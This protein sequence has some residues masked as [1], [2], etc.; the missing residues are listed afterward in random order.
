MIF[1]QS[2]SVSNN[3]RG[4]LSLLWA[5][6]FNNP[7]TG[8]IQQQS[9]PDQNTSPG[10]SDLLGLKKTRFQFEFSSG[11]R[12]KLSIIV[13][14]DALRN[15]KDLPSKELD[16]RLGDSLERSP[17]LQFLD[18]YEI[19]LTPFKALSASFGVFEEI[20]R[21]IEAY[22][23]N[24]AFSLELRSISKTS[25]I[26]LRWLPESQKGS[27]IA[28]DLIVFQGPNERGELNNLSSTDARSIKYGA[29]GDRKNGG[30]LSANI[31]TSDLYLIYSFLSYYES[32]MIPNANNSRLFLQFGVQ[33][34]FSVMGRD[35]NLALD[36]RCMIEVITR[37]SDSLESAEKEMKRNHFSGKISGLFEIVPEFYALSHFQYAINMLPDQNLSELED[38]K[39]V[40]GYQFELGLR[41][42]E[43]Q[44]VYTQ[45]LLTEEARLASSDTTP[46]FLTE[47]GSSRNFVQRLSMSVSYKF[48]SRL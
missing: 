5:D 44:G 3:M 27:S 26:L 6:E 7:I 33:H 19:Q 32:Q 36:S 1:A 43:A 46:A 4:E 41:S 17:S 2:Q 48:D 18:A 10:Q 23:S 31:L 28:L 11:K 47:S 20:N 9:N 21:P 30:A 37:Q 15:N 25:G 22:E 38:A 24:L 29:T 40:S 35:L 16:T 42:G 34:Q 45:I 8:V 13:R 39:K 14:P 12:S